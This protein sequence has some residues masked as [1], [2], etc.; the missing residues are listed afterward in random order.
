MGLA[1]AF[2]FALGLALA[3]TLA[4]A[5]ALAFT[6]ALALAL[7]G[8]TAAR[9]RGR[10]PPGRSSY[11]IRRPL[12]QDH[13]DAFD[14][15][16]KHSP[17]LHGEGGYRHE[18]CCHSQEVAQPA[19]LDEVSLDGERVPIAFTRESDRAAH[20]QRKSLWLYARGCRG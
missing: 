17:L 7:G 14:F 11:C 8:M 6:I 5:L 13:D 1:L 2:T 15:N 12:F 20:T 19:G 4:R 16:H 3:F 9:S 18:L 10:R